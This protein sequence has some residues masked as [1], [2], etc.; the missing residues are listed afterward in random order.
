MSKKKQLM[1]YTL[2]KVLGAS[3]LPRI[4]NRSETKTIFVI[5]T[6]ASS[7]LLLYRYIFISWPSRRLSLFT[8]SSCVLQQSAAAFHHFDLVLAEFM[9]RPCFAKFFNQEHCDFLHVS[10]G[11]FSFCV[12]V[13]QYCSLA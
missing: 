2:C 12:C 8:F 1:G 6:I 4:L 13:R 10:N 9:R 7:V 3:Q 11:K 5:R